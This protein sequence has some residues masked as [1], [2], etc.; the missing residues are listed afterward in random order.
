M[1]F[2][3]GTSVGYNNV[4]PR[5]VVERMTYL[6]TKGKCTQGQISMVRRCKAAHENGLEAFTLFSVA[7][8][9]AIATGVQDKAA[10]SSVCTLFL[11][12]RAAYNVAYVFGTNDA[13][14]GL[15][16]LFWFVG[17]GCSGSLL[18]AAAAAYE[19]SL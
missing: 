4:E 19:A 11:A 1:I 2:V 13:L 10:T 3:V 16:S 8:L 15:R 14:A 7:V 18:M 12:S 6:E 17:Q 9:A 5:Q